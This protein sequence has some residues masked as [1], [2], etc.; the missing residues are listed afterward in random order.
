M[1]KRALC[2]GINDY[3]IEGADLRGCLNDADGWASLLV[4]HF[5][6]A[7]S[8]IVMLRDREATKARILEGLKDLLASASA[9]DVLV[10]TN[11]SH[12]SYL[13]DESGDES[14]AYDEVI[15]PYDIQENVLVDDELREILDGVPDGARVTVISD[16]CHSGSVTRV[17]PE[18]FLPGF[19]SGD[20]RRVRFLSPV[21]F[22]DAQEVRDRD[23]FPIMGD[24]LRARSTRREKFPESEMGH[25]LLAGCMDVEVSYDAKIDDSF[26]GAMTY[27]ALKA[28]AD[29]NYEITY[30][31][32]VDR[33]GPALL[34]AQF[35]Q[36]PQ[37]EGPDE[38]K[39]RQV[40]V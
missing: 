6:F 2:V 11:S 12:G 22:K 36:H 28:I 38:A 5:D 23:A 13:R 33:L 20:E 21:Y 30:Q 7:A 24:A 27:H 14:D 9:G 34:D 17:I 35:P 32:L 18:E 26:H 8:D 39:D 31:A 25:V 15:C 19:V 4:G 29:A 3:P 40:F 1:T 16:S 37:L 10:F